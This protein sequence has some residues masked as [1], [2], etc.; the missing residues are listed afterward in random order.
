[1]KTISLLYTG[2]QTLRQMVFETTYNFKENDSR[3]WHSFSKKYYN[4]KTCSRKGS[5]FLSPPQSKHL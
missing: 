1:M 3:L 2:T 4:G 5:D